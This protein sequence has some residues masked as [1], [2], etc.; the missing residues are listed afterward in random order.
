MDHFA[1]RVLA[2]LEMDA[3]Y[4]RPDKPRDSTW[5]ER[6]DNKRKGN[7]DYGGQEEL[8]DDIF[9][10]SPGSIA[11]AL[12]SRSKDMQQALARLSFYRNRSGKNIPD[13]ENSRLDQARDAIYRAYGELPPEDR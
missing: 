2:S 11:N 6:T 13:S 4:Y 3:R 1:M 9:K 8:P 7:Y 10:G 5:I 12:K